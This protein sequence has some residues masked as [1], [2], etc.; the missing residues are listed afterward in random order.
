MYLSRTVAATN[1]NETS[2]RSH[3]VFTIVVSQRHFDNETNLVG[4]KVTHNCVECL[5]FAD[6][7]LRVGSKKTD[8]LVNRLKCRTGIIIVNASNII[9]F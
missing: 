1:M 2:S 8:K 7:H 9:I 4:E 5:A 6:G 3:A